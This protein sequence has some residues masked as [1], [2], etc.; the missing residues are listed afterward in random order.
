MRARALSCRVGLE[1]V[2]DGKECQLTY[3]V[4]R[5]LVPRIPRLS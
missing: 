5:G 4:M 1:I 2:L 3:S